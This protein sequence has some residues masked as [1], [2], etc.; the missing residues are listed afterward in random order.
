MSFHARLYESQAFENWML[1]TIKDIRTFKYT[2]NASLIHEEQF[3]GAWH[4]ITYCLHWQRKFHFQWSLVL[5]ATI[6]GAVINVELHANEPQQTMGERPRDLSDQLCRNTCYRPAVQWL[7]DLLQ[8]NHC[9]CWTLHN[10]FGIVFQ[11]ICLPLEVFKCAFIV[12]Y[13]SGLHW[14]SYS[15]PQ[16]TNL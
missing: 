7:S 15:S 11:I 6:R 16:A 13:P 1:M 2:V 8:L 10:W 4:C 9:Q 5:D 14:S 12:S 3:S